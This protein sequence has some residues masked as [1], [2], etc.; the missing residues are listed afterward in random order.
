MGNTVTNVTAGKPKIGGAV[1][2]API[3][4]ALPTTADATLNEAFLCLGYCS[5][6]GVTNT[7]TINSNATNA[8]G[9]DPV[10]NVQTSKTDEWGLTLIEALNIDV[11]KVAFGDSNVS[12]A[13]ATGITVSVNATE[14]AAAEYVIDMIM[15]N[16]AKKRVVLPNAKVT[17]IGTITYNDSDPVGYET[18]LSALADASGNTHYEYIKSA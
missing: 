6:A 3:G 15:T 17:A 4:T 5:D 8:W 12:G 11:L 18:T 10:L 7:L 16:G 13:L 2:R 1:Y 9:G 14:Q